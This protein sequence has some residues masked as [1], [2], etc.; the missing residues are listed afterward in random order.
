MA[1]LCTL[2]TIVCALLAPAG[3][4]A[5]TV[6][7]TWSCCG[8]GGAS[9]QT[10]TIAESAGSLSGTASESTPFAP[11]SGSISGTSV[12]IVTGPYT[13]DPGYTA[14]FVGTIA[15]NG[16]T[17]SGTWSSN[18][19]QEGTWTATRTSSPSKEQEE[20][21]AAAKKA[22]EEKEKAEKEAAGKRKPG[23][24]VNC[25]TFDP[26]LTTEYFQCTA[27]LGDASGRSPA[28][29]PTGTVTFTLEPGGGGR[30]VGSNLCTLTPSQTGGASS[31]CAV[32]Y[33]PRT[34]EAIPL[35][36]QPPI[37]ANYAGDVNFS[38]IGGKPSGPV[39]R[40]ALTEANVYE[41]L[42]KGSSFAGCT[43]HDPT[44]TALTEVCASLLG[45]DSGCLS[46]TT[47]CDSPSGEVTDQPLTLSENEPSVVA[48]VDCPPD[49]AVTE[50]PLTNCELEML[51]KGSTDP[52]LKAKAEYY[53][54]Y[55][56]FSAKLNEIKLET[57]KTV[58]AALEIDSGQRAG[59]PDDVYEKNKNTRK[60]EAL[61][62]SKAAE[63]YYEE[64]NKAGTLPIHE[65][66]TYDV[67]KTCAVYKYEG[68]EEYFK[69]V[70]NV[71]ETG[72]KTARET[73]IEYGVA[74]PFKLPTKASASASA[75]R[76]GRR[77]HERPG[78]PGTLLA[79]ASHITVAAGTHR[80]V[81]LVVPSY[82]R[83]NL[84]RFYARGV[85]TLHAKLFVQVK[86]STG[87]AT[88]KVIPLTVHL[89]GHGPAT[90]RHG[91]KHSG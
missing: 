50:G 89:M 63:E 25:D 60:A 70:N 82:A 13:T 7:G 31:F 11:I 3:A 78:S 51:F 64:L 85:R 86:L 32:E 43:G 79:Y 12:T 26:G 48:E 57:V 4:T 52:A 36:A 84:K 80:K 83:A 14:T 24:Q 30:F 69:A 39:A 19:K 47:G 54:Q 6:T 20:Q 44:Q 65:G 21:A 9:A 8:S 28:E 81:R 71:L 49:A 17:M 61:A 87:G 74:V 56:K 38:A 2:P 10:W 29:L 77:I 75:V 46:A 45:C 18:A 76:R 41:A 40:M 68:C 58:E 62:I 88:T 5:A 33:K 53:G 15:A 34:Q 91:S 23:I 55:K 59:E 1:A 67:G 66:P 35:G 37:A 42:C 90:R 72:Y 73:K 16:E 27:Q 22:Q